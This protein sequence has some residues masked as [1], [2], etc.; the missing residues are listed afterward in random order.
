MIL[1]AFRRPVS[2]RFS[3]TYNIYVKVQISTYVLFENSL[4]DIHFNLHKVI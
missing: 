4:Q 3:E 2:L 1:S